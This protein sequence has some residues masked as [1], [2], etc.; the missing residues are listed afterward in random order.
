V[1]P[2]VINIPRVDGGM[3]REVIDFHADQVQMIVDSG[4]ALASVKVVA[5]ELTEINSQTSTTSESSNKA[6]SSEVAC[7][8]DDKGDL[9]CGEE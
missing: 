8:V 6:A 7:T 9:N 4:Y 2:A 1:P 5:P 3:L